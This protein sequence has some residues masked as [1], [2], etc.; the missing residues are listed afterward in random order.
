MFDVEFDLAQD[1]GGVEEAMTAIEEII[2]FPMAHP[3][4]YD[5]YVQPSLILFQ[6]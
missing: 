1:L 6:T 4:L 3:E 5:W 2:L